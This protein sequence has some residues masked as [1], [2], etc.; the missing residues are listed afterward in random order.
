MLKIEQCLKEMRGPGYG[1]GLSLV[2]GRWPLRCGLVR[3]RFGFTWAVDGCGSVLLVLTRTTCAVTQYTQIWPAH[4]P[5]PMP[6]ARMLLR[7]LHDQA[8]VS[9]VA[10]PLPSMREC[11]NPSQPVSAEDSAAILK[12]LVRPRAC[13]AWISIPRGFFTPPA[14]LQ[15]HI[16]ATVH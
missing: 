9:Q 10:P 15:T 5:A 14:N 3:R 7:L 13:L 6:V 1:T 8:C 16:M 11:P 2:C 4:K 12:R